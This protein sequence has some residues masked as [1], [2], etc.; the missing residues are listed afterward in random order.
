MPD[1]SHQGQ[2]Q[3]CPQT[4]NYKEF[5]LEKFKP[6]SVMFWINDFS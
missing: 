6:L 2:N 4:L 1:E 5:T 3:T